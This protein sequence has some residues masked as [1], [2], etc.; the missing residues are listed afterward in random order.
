VEV[1]A[2][3]SSVRAK[4][5]ELEQTLSRSNFWLASGFR[6]M[7]TARQEPHNCRAKRSPEA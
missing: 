7:G 6:A 1:C 5:A 4:N 2:N 3:P